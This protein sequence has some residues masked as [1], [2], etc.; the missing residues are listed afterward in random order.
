MVFLKT[1]MNQ[2]QAG[3]TSEEMKSRGQLLQMGGTE[4]FGN[5]VAHGFCK[6]E[7]FHCQSVLSVRTW[8]QIKARPVCLHRQRVTQCWPGEQTIPGHFFLN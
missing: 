3:V 1:R 5:D 6:I 7:T 4:R 2:A 8:P